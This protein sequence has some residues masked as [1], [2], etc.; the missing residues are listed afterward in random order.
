MNQDGRY[1]TLTKQITTICLL[2]T[3]NPKKMSVLMVQISLNNF[4][5]LMI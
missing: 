3:G 1:K 5:L 2:F 4:F